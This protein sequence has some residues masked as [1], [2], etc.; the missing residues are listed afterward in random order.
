MSV[1]CRSALRELE[2][3]KVDAEGGL[4]S[5]IVRHDTDHASELF[6]KGQGSKL[7]AS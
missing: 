2:E 7:Y 1:G 4:M 6:L 5:A 3:L